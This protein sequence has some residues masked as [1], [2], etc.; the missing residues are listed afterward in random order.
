MK[1]DAVLFKHSQKANLAM[2]TMIRVPVRR[3]ARLHLA[4]VPVHYPV[5]W[6][7]TQ[8]GLHR[9]VGKTEKIC[10]CEDLLRITLLLTFRVTNIRFCSN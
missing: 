6:T 7:G 10:A 5:E 9:N 3:S 4:S 8:A 1:K 2:L